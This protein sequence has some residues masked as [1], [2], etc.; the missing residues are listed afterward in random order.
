M[1]TQK[2]FSLNQGNSKPICSIVIRAYNEEQHIGKLLTGITQQSIKDLEII[3]VDSGSTD[4]TVAIASRF[5]VEIIHIHPD[6]F[7]FGYALNEGIKNAQGEYIVIASAHVYPVYPDWIKQLLSPF[8]DPKIAL[9]YGK[10]RGNHD[11]V[12]PE[13][14]IF[15]HWFPEASVANQSHPFCNNANAAIRRS[16][17]EKHPYNESLTGLEDLEWANWAIKKGYL[18]AYVAEAEIV[19]IHH[20]IPKAVYNRYR[21]EA[22]AFKQI[23][24]E[25]HFGFWDFLRLYSSN[26]FSDSW[27]ALKDGMLFTNIKNILW[28]RFMQF[29]GTYRGYQQTGPI[30]P[31]LRQ[32]FYYPREFH[33]GREKSSRD[34]SPIDY[35]EEDEIV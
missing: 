12:F 10:Q 20:E 9:T 1:I 17:W 14:Q 31:S 6:E 5:P 23:F 24:P 15:A 16:L 3:L 35:R 21:R 28:F 4:A 34:L 32:T 8:L 25:E 19:H 18:L 29:W 2:N 26:V 13:R 33:S 27:H 30:N 22:M 7:T 11:S